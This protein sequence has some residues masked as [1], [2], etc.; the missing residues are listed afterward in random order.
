MSSKQVIV[1]YLHYHLLWSCVRV[2]SDVLT[3]TIGVVGAP[4]KNNNGVR[5]P[6]LKL[7]STENACGSPH[8]LETLP[9]DY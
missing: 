4:F 7:Q 8:F 2:V 5:F 6:F 1:S 9:A 3:N